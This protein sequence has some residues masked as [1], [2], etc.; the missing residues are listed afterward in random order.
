MGAG[1]GLE[2]IVV[3]DAGEG[4]RDLITTGEQWQFIGRGGYLKMDPSHLENSWIIPVKTN[5]CI[6]Y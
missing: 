3:K 6:L 1:F 5:V 2:G 4:T